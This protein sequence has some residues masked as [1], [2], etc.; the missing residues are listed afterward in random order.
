MNPD[1]FYRRI[2]KITALS[3]YDRYARLSQFHTELVICYLDLVRSMSGK[4]AFQT[5][6]DGRTVG[7]VVAHI[8]E[9]ERFTI[10]AAGEMVSGVQCPQIM[11]LCGYVE[12][13]GS[14]K[15]FDSVDQFSAYQMHKYADRPWSE[16]KDIALHTATALHGLFT[17]PA[18]L[19]PDTIQRTK[20]VEW[21]LPTGLKLNLPVGWY[22]WMTAIEREVVSHAEDL[23]WPA[24]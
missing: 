15:S 10:Q 6:T 17:Q 2:A 11:N 13:D 12:A 20:K 22:L 14:A 9:W 19:S 18:L 21:R 4:D 5:G 7:Q 1:L 3:P 16:I 8:A 24:A 23:G